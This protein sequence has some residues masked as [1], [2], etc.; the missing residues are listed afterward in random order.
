MRY[1]EKV[2]LAI[3]NAKQP[4]RNIEEIAVFNEI[5]EIA[6]FYEKQ[7]VYNPN[8][9]E[10]KPLHGMGTRFK[11]KHIKIIIIVLLLAIKSIC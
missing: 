2:D 3:L 7:C 5:G 9:F 4:L 8:F 10:G 1:W 6:L 11:Q